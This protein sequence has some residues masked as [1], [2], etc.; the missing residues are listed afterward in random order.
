MSLSASAENL[1]AEGLVSESFL[2]Y[3]HITTCR[4][5]YDS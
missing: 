5:V 4:G 1:T 2:R 3:I